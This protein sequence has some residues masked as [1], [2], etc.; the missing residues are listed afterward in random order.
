[1]IRHCVMFRWNEG[2]SDEHVAAASTALE[3][4]K[5]AIPVIRSSSHGP[6]LGVVAGNFSYGATMQFENLDDFF[7]YRE[8]P[9]HVAF[10]STY[11][12]GFV[13]ERAA[14]QFSD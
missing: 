5:D 7:T 2:V 3:A 4:L 8:H 11:L 10:V 13:S 9:A 14:V 1:M 6:D 12:T